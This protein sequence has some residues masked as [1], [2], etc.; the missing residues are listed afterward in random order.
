LPD[1]GTALEVLG[2]VIWSSKQGKKTSGKMLPPGM[3]VKFLNISTENI[4]RIISVLSQ[5]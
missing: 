3:G 1:A 5:L 2:E 4:K